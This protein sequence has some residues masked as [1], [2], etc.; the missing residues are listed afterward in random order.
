M[1]S[2][3]GCITRL[4]TWS[5]RLEEGFL[6]L[7]LLAMILLACLQIALRLLFSEGL[8]WAD[9]L[10]RYM[11]VWSGMFGAAVA[12]KKGKHIALDVASYLVPAHLQ[13][14]LQLLIHLFSTL[15]SAALTWA[16]VLFVRNEAEFGGTTLLAMP[17]WLW[18]LVFPLAFGLI[19]C[20]FFAAA[21]AD[22]RTIAGRFLPV[23]P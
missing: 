13:S 11:V 20:R 2:C 16:A 19:T 4:R 22:I 15:V 14:W 9:P 18:N 23:K 21:L 7:L 17:S 1:K 3:S 8:L 6:C 12:T 10:L 5:Q